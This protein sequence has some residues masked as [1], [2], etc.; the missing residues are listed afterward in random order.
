MKNPTVVEAYAWLASY[1]DSLHGGAVARADASIS[2]LEG[3]DLVE[4]F[5]GLPRYLRLRL[6]LAG[7]MLFRM[8]GPVE[9]REYDQSPLRFAHLHD[10][11]RAYIG[12]EED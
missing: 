2:S 11:V 1:L 6:R 10:E 4:D 7:S 3:S 12:T 9:A 5:K 8:M